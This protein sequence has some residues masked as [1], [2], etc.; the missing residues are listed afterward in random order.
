MRTR[1][2]LRA[3]ALAAALGLA[4][5]AAFAHDETKY[6]NLKGQWVRLAKDQGGQWDPAKPPGRGQQPPLTAAY[7][8]AWEATLAARA[9]GRPDATPACL[10]PGMPRSMIGYGPMEF[11][12]MPAITFVMLSHMN[13]LRRIFTDGRKWPDDPDPSFGGY[14]IGHWEDTDGRG[15]FDTLMVETRAIKGPHTLDDSGI[16]V[17]K[18][19]QTVVQE[20]IYLDKTDANLLHDEV[21]TIDHAFTKPWTVT[22]TYQREPKTAWAEPVCAESNKQVLLGKE[23][24]LLGDDGSLRPT[25]PGQPA[26]DVHYFNRNR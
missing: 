16:P 19:N 18:D 9:A 1:I 23:S 22:R 26:P 15:R 8:K 5:S 7:Q 14:S 13:E 17:D 6:P 25:R 10:P 3:I 12:P 24:Y 20:K 4:A 21:T 11:I 2:S